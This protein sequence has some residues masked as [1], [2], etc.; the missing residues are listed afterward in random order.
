MR[1]TAGDLISFL[2]S[3]AEWIPDMIPDLRSIT[4]PAYYHWP[5]ILFGFRIRVLASETEPVQDL[6]NSAVIIVMFRD[7]ISGFFQ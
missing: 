7:I 5:Q 1:H 4:W 3:E 2:N 6:C